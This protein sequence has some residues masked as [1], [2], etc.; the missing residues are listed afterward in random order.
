MPEAETEGPRT[1]F[2]T[3]I[4]FTHIENPDWGTAVTLL[5]K[6]GV[7]GVS[8]YEDYV[9]ANDERQFWYLDDPEKKYHVDCL[10][11][12]FCRD[13]SE[14]FVERF[15]VVKT[16]FGQRPTCFASQN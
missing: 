10:G 12:A 15:H 5:E 14:E 11:T 16:E 8:K 2:S 9:M 13:I 1:F 3:G 6:A 7:I 4:P